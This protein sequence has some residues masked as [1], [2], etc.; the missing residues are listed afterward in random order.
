MQHHMEYPVTL[1][2]Q[3]QQNT[4]ENICMYVNHEGPECIAFIWFLS[5][6]LAK[7]TE[8]VSVA[9]SWQINISTSGI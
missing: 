7:Q 2:N 5:N 4:H 3:I 1:V 6:S 8:V 9:N